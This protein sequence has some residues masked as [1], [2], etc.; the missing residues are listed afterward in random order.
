M[1]TPLPVRSVHGKKV[2]LFFFKEKKIPGL[3]FS[4]AATRLAVVRIEQVMRVCQMF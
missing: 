1:Q 4:L 2:F 3:G